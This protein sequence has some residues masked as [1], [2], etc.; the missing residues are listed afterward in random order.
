MTKYDV[1]VIGSGIGGLAF[2]AVASSRLG[3]KILILEKN[4]TVGG[5]LHSFQREGFTLDIGA[6]VIS[7]SE[8]GPLGSVLRT[9]GKEGDIS[10]KH[11]RPM[12]SYC[13]EIF[14]FPKGL[15]GRISA[16][17]Y[18][19]LLHT[20]KELLSMDDP[21]SRE[22]DDVDLRAYLIRKGICDP[23]VLACFNNIVMIYVCVPYHRASAGEFIRCFRE[24]ARSRAS[25]YPVGGCGVISK[26]LA[27][28]IAEHGGFIRTSSEV[29]EIIVENGRAVGVRTENAEYRAP[30]V[31]SNADGRR[32]LIDLLPQGILPDKERSRVRD[33]TYSY[34]MLIVR[35]ALKHSVTDLK[36]ITHIVA[37]LDPERYEEDLLAGR[38]PDEMPL[39]MPVPSNFSPECAPE[40]GQLITAGSIIPYETP[41][42][43]RLEKIVVKTAEKILPGLKD[44]LLWRHVT[45]PED[46][47]V[48]VR[49]N[50]AI[51][52]L[53]Q[54]VD[55]VGKR[56]LDVETLVPGLFLCGAE[57]G[58]TGVGIELAINSSFELLAKL[59]EKDSSWKDETTSP[60]V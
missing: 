46:L 44:A 54:T 49:E 41:D 47:H 40:G 57:A 1:I 12:T 6:H 21:A 55:Q 38:F 35:M 10:W 11:V 20:T 2:A 51:I 53:G 15:E 59:G 8:K 28:G 5:R 4:A 52:G 3:K 7:Q 16:D 19:R 25:G 27:D 31:V 14:A 42:V 18:S 60:L 36:L 24:E 58:G 43:D 9:L 26:A 45:T 37:G 23:L 32:T 29:K 50:G 39:F 17:Q 48:A 13:G 56:R 30:I 33:M 22:L 34:S